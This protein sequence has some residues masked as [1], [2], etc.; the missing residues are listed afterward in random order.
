[1]K[2][3]LLFYYFI[4]LRRLI[5]IETTP[6]PVLIYITA[7]GTTVKRKAPDPPGK[8]VT[9]VVVSQCAE[10]F[11]PPP[12]LTPRARRMPDQQNRALLT[13]AAPCWQLSACG[14]WVTASSPPYSSRSSSNPALHPCTI[15]T[16]VLVYPEELKASPAACPGGCRKELLKTPTEA[17]NPQQLKFAQTMSPLH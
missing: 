11:P 4:P 8:A 10:S 15:P 16:L 3:K 17:H 13:L 2:L 5:R 12:E 7:P 14:N 1:M 9:A 6:T